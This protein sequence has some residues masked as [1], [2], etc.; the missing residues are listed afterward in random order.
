MTADVGMI[1]LNEW[2]SHIIVIKK[3]YNDPTTSEETKIQLRKFL[4]EIKTE[5]DIW[6]A[7][8]S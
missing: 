4:K 5:L 8:E 2:W 6:I 1:E 3:I 7:E